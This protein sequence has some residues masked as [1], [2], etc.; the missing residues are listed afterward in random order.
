MGWSLAHK[1]G[2]VHRDIKPS[3]LL[4]DTEGT[5]KNRYGVVNLSR[6][7]GGVAAQAEL[8]GTGAV[9]GTVDYMAPEQ[10]MSTHHAD[11]RAVYL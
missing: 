8:T 3:N 5:V 11:A 10:A 1:K 6:N 7:W 2:V 4:L 9:M